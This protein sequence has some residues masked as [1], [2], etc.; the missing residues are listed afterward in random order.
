MTHALIADIARPEHRGSAFGLANL[1]GEIGA[2]L[3]PVVAGTLRDQY[4]GWA[5]AIY[6]DCAIILVSFVSLSFLRER[7]VRA[8]VAV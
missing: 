5:P 1:I 8:P 6:L 2:V 3:S 4:G 7:I